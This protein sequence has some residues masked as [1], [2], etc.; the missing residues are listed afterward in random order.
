MPAIR[1]HLKYTALVALPSLL[2]ILQSNADLAEAASP[3]HPVIP[4]F[5][6]IYAAEG[7]DPVEGGRLL[8]T[9]LNCVSCHNDDGDIGK[10]LKAKQAP[11]LDAVGSRVEIEWL[12]KFLVSTHTE[13]AGTTMPD[14][15]AGLNDIERVKQVTALT[16]FLAQTGTI[17]NAM[18]DSAAVGRGRNLFHSIGCVACHAPIKD[19]VETPANS[20][21]LGAIAD[22]YSLASLTTFL[23]NPLAVRPSGRMPDFKLDD[24][25]TR[26]I[27][28]FFFRDKKIEAHVNYAYYE[29]GWQKLPDFSAMKPKTQGQASN[30]DVEVRQKNDGFGLRFTGFIHLPENGTTSF[31]D[32]T[33]AAGCWLTISR[34]S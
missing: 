3:E 18:G 20:V 6:R 31:S 14:L 23:K 30:F 34:S 29:G 32:Q 13:K 10:R 4:G 19:G 11:I 2:L 21:P 33:M 12:Q 1:R 15:F 28:S 27:A 7:A 5:E 16:H 25:Q 8:L 17:A 24:K 26:D 9:E 22:K